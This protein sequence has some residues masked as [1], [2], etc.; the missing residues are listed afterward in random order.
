MKPAPPVWRS[1]PARI[2]WGAALGA[3]TWPLDLAC[4]VVALV[5]A[6]RPTPP[7][8]VRALV[9]WHR[10]RTARFLGWADDGA[11][12]TTR[13]AAGYLLARV[14]V[15][16]VGT[17]VLGLLAYGLFA[18]VAGLLSWLFDIRVTVVDPESS[19]GLTTGALLAMVPVGLVLLYLDL[20]GLVGV[21][22]L[23]RAAAARWFSPSR[24][25]RL[26]AQVESL[27]VSRADLLAALDAERGRIE[28]D[29]HDGV[30]Q[31]A[32]AV[33]LLVNRARRAVAPGSS[34][35]LLLEQAGREAE[36][37]VTDLRDVAWRVRPTTLDTHG[38]EPVLRELVAH[39]AVPTV[40]DWGAA[41]RLPSGV[42]T[43]VYYV[44]AEAL[45]NV[46]KHSGAG[47]AR[48]LVS[49]AGQAVGSDDGRPDGGVVHVV[50]SDD[51]VGGAVARPGHGLAGLAGRVA[52]AGGALGVVSPVGGPT[53]IEVTLPC[54]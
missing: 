54:A 40:L 39:A 50:I 9:A 23:D 31:R 13:R 12:L 6:R 44:V 41:G 49:V 26:E 42:E 5:G 43:T 1:T 16:L 20:M 36:R 29:L 11:P 2:L 22:L 30:Q 18:A 47:E 4:A 27:T 15:G 14:G 53:R 45:T 52:A 8:P 19:E 35:A 46:A 37:L 25:E 3:L 10:R 33:G 51:G 7:G 24:S 38:L 34:G 48:V 32:V 21:G 17:L 28:R